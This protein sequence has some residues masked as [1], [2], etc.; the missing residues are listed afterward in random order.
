MHKT[1]KKIFKKDISHLRRSTTS[2]EMEAII[3]SPKKEKPRT[4]RIHC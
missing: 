3:K 2:N 4:K 1:C